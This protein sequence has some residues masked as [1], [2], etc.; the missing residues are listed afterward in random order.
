VAP[1]KIIELARANEVHPSLP[2]KE[3]A[4]IGFEAFNCFT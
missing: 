3:E 2:A 4:D 1:P